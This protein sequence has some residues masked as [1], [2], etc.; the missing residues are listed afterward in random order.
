MQCTSPVQ[1]TRNGT[2]RELGPPQPTLGTRCKSLGVLDGEWRHR[3]TAQTPSACLRIGLAEPCSSTSFQG[4]LEA[5]QAVRSRQYSS[6]QPEAWDSWPHS[7]ES[8]G[9][10]SQ[11]ICHW[12][13]LLCAGPV[14]PA[15]GAGAVG[16]WEAGLCCP[17]MGGALRPTMKL[18]GILAICA[19]ICSRPGGCQQLGMSGTLVGPWARGGNVLVNGN[20]E[21]RVQGAGL[22]QETGL[23]AC[24][25]L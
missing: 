9:F 3:P 7:C 20:A 1:L 15:A 12:D 4:P 10:P 13:P 11:G 17:G 18:G 2:S 16:G 14:V 22:V 5:L 19:C 23:L 25:L 8:H 24:T 21:S 6:R